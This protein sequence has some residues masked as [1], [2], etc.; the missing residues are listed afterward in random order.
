MFRKVHADF[1]GAQRQC[2]LEF[3]GTQIG[4]WTSSMTSRRSGSTAAA[5]LTPF[6]ESA[7]AVP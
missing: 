6:T 3:R 4:N 5:P 2:E 1:A 7:D